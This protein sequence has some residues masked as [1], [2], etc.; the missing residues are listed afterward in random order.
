MQTYEARDLIRRCATD[1]DARTWQEFQNRFNRPLAMGVRRTL[2]RF[3][4]RISDD[5]HQD[6]L[7]ETY[8]RL[9]EGQGR[10]L[11]GCRGEVEGAISAY[12]SRVAE[13]VVVD[14]LRGRNA[15][16]R[17][18][19]IVVE[20]RRCTGTDLAD[21]MMDPRRTPEE[22]LLLRE[23]HARF[24]A[25]CGKLVGKR[26]R[27][28]DLQ[29]LYLAFFEGWTSREICSRLG[30]GMKPST[31]DSLVHRL[32]KRLAALGIDVPRRRSSRVFVVDLDP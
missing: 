22:R 3:D 21:R 24:L 30:Q 20:L 27:T 11:R 19:G 32:K 5:E 12:L 9:L 7:Q 28:R 15:A 2:L 6:L 14:F 25:K 1:R 10:R 31:V 16:K 17:G 18:G 4:A 26:S 8:C 29:V 13:S 23:R